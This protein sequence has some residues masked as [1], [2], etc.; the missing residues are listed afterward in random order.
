MWGKITG[1]IEHCDLNSDGILKVR[2]IDKNK[3]N[4]S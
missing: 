2:E 1:P 3:N 4:K